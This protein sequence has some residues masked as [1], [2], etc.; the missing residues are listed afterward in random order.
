MIRDILAEVGLD[1]SPYL[2]GTSFSIRDIPCQPYGCP[3]GLYNPRTNTI[4][5]PPNFTADALLHEV[6]HR[7]GHATTGN[8]SEKFAEDFRKQFSNGAALIAH[9]Q[10]LPNLGAYEPLFAEGERGAVVAYFDHNL[11]RSE[12]SQMRR[13]LPPSVGLFINGSQAQATFR[14]KMPMLLLIVP[15][16]IMAGM[17]GWGLMKIPSAVAKNIVPLVL[18]GGGILILYTMARK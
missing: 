9:G 2:V 14:K 10:E 13:M 5:L 16:V 12:I 11:S 15:M 3:L 8:L 18:I 17:V 6:G 4:I 1:R 7:V